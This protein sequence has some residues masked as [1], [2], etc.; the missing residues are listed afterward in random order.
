VAALVLQ[1]TFT[2]V[3]SFAWR[4]LMPPFLVR[5]PFDNLAAV[6]GFTGPVLVIHGR[7]DG[8]IPFRHGEALA[9]AAREGS[10]VPLECGH[11]DCPPDW[12]AYLD[13]LEA[14]LRGE[15][16]LATPRSGPP[17]G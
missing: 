13:I 7:R 3:R 12:S 15:G 2:S 5:D 4:Y 1:S 14:F 16:L 11:N 17:P 9:A 10:L 6:R 8:I